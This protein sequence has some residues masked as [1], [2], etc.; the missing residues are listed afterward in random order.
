VRP[1][2]A[3]RV[4]SNHWEVFGFAHRGSWRAVGA[5]EFRSHRRWQGQVA[6]E[7]AGLRGSRLPFGGVRRLPAK[8]IIVGQGW[9]SPTKWVLA[10][11]DHVM[12][13][14]SIFVYN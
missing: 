13:L 2:K 7:A 9:R 12:L 5:S 10:F 14:L 6:G 4:T 8:S 3:K 11:V 1:N